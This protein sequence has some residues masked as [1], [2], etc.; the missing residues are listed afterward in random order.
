MTEHLSA[1]V[2]GVILVLSSSLHN[3]D[4]CVFLSHMFSLLSPVRVSPL[5]S[6]SMKQLYPHRSADQ[7]LAVFCFFNLLSR[8]EE[9]DF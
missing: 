1:Y 8:K 6:H 9:T 5:C 3:I 7:M 4:D 2:T